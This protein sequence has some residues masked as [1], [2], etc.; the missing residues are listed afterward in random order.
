MNEDVMKL[1]LER[2]IHSQAIYFYDEEEMLLNRYPDDQQHYNSR[3]L[4]CTV[5]FLVEH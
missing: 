1:E 3:R 5:P 2:I 4:L